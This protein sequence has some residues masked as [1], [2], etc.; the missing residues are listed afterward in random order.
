M[1]NVCRKGHISE[2]SRR[3]TEGYAIDQDKEVYH[4]VPPANE[5]SGYPV[6]VE[7]QS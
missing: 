4:T 3:T 6:D 5:L 1:T 7:K 2:F